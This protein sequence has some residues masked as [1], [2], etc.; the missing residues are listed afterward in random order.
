MID[1][2]IRINILNYNLILKQNQFNNFISISINNF[3]NT[4]RFELR[5]N[6]IILSN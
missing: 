1:K 6:I 2:K 4:E 3:F 5:I